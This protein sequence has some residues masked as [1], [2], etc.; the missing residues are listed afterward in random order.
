MTAF[1]D[2]QPP[3]RD[4]AF[5][6]PNVWLFGLVERF[7]R[8]LH[9]NEVLCTLRCV[10]KATAEQFRGRPEFATVRLSQPVPPLAFAAR[11]AAPGAMRE[12]SLDQRKQL[13]RL[14]AASGVA[15]N[16]DVA[17][18]A[19]GFVP[20]SGEL[21]DFYLA[22]SAAGHADVVHCLMQ[23]HLIDASVLSDAMGIAAAAGHG[24]V[25]EVL[26]S[27]NS[28][29]QW[30]TEHVTS[31]LRGGHPELA[32]WLLQ[33]R[34]EGAIGPGDSLAP[35]GAYKCSQLLQAAAESCDLPTLRSL[36]QR[37]GHVGVAIPA[38]VLGSAAGSR[39]ADWQAKVEWA[40]SQL[41]PDFRPSTGVC[42]A[43]VPCSDAE[44]RL[45]WLLARGYPATA[46]VVDRALECGC[47]AALELLLRRGLQP[48][49][50]AVEN[51]ARQGRLE[52]LKKL[53][54]HGCPLNAATVALAAGWSGHSAVR[55]W[56]VEEL[57]APE[58]PY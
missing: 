25:C 2:V 37:C 46:Y 57:G 34:P 18:E 56:A 58:D 43:A 26:F 42:A 29:T 5:T 1:A 9:P 12:L 8:F 20:D 55:A 22:A 47:V 16:L 44:L 27:S 28:S 51:A 30:K 14:T 45:A 17:L 39:T 21:K 41:P 38:A 3:A 32:D 40:E 10:D 33:R 6:L 52:A 24:T 23:R 48:G 7:V 49:R 35:L 31:A 36:H 54:E 15:A 19:V 4:A 13:L 50:G 11:W 53:H